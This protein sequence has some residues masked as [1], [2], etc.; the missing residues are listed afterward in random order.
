VGVFKNSGACRIKLLGTDKVVLGTIV[1]S[2]LDE[3]NNIYTRALNEGQVL[4]VIAKPT[5]KDGEL[6]KLYIT[7]A[8][9][10]EEPEQVP[11]MVLA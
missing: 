4:Q 7:S 6:Y 8:S 1:D 11:G 5:L 9:T 10:P 2:A 3:P